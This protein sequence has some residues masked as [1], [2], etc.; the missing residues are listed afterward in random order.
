MDVIWNISYSS[1][2]NSFIETGIN[3]HVWS[4]LLLHG[5]FLGFFL[6]T[7]SMDVFVHVFSGH[8]LVDGVSPLV[9]P[10]FVGVILPGLS[11][12]DSMY[13]FGE[14]PLQFFFLQSCLSYYSC[15][16][17]ILFTFFVLCRRKLCYTLGHRLLIS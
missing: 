16:L 2:P 4:S 3:A 14:K 6:E 8:L 10:F 7:H 15:M 17:R 12:K 11:W 1:G 5:K 9:T 13:F